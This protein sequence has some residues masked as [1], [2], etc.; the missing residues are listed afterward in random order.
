MEKVILADK[1]YTVASKTNTAVNTA[2]EE[3]VKAIKALSE[4]VSE[5][6]YK[7]Y[8]ALVE[9]CAKAE[10]DYQVALKAQG[11]SEANCGKVAEA[12]ERARRA[13]EGNFAY[14]TSTAPTTGGGTGVTGGGAGTPT[15]PKA[16][17]TVILPPAAVPLAGPGAADGAMLADADEEEEAGL[18]TL[19]DEVTPLAGPESKTE[20]VNLEDFPTPL[21]GPVAEMGQMSWWWLLIIAVLG[22]TGEEMYRRYQ[23]KQREQANIES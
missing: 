2:Y 22:I 7:A 16:A 1:K 5:E 10:R 6:A 19:E 9:K 20:T 11:V 23:K 18:T 13:A 8:E 3:T 17:P 12:V 4:A 21:A 15:A 14:R